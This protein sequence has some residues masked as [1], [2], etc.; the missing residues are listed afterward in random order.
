[1]KAP[2]FNRKKILIPISGVR[3]IIVAIFSFLPF[4]S[5]DYNIIIIIILDKVYSICCDTNY[6]FSEYYYHSCG[7]FLI[8][9]PGCMIL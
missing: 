9:S 5:L 1:M 7:H 6:L 3:N 8:L 4:P 2:P